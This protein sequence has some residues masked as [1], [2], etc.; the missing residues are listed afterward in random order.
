YRLDRVLYLWNVLRGEMSLV[1]PSAR[2]VDKASY[3]EDWTMAYIHSR[4]PGLI[5]PGKVFARK[6][7]DRDLAELYDGYYGKFGGLGLDMETLMRSIPRLFRGESSL[8]R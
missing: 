3:T 4:R 5:G 1:G 2:L 8:E 7:E 6:S